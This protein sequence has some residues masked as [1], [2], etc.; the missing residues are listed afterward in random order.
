[1][2][3]GIVQWTGIR[4]G[5]LGLWLAV[6]LGVTITSLMPQFAPP[7]HHQ[8]DKILHFAVYF[9]LAGWIAVALR[10]P[11]PI[12]AALL[13][14]ILVGVGIEL[15]QTQTPG[16]MVSFSD[17]LVNT[18]GVVAGAFLARLANRFFCWVFSHHSARQ[19]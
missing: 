8:N 7:V 16:R 13:Y 4:F 9:A 19:D 14:L 12:L 1:M 6:I 11:L 10:Q 5:I 18:V 3:Q 17:A 15:A 2:K